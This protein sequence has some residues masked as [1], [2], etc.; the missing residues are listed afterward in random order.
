MKRLIYFLIF[1]ICLHNCGV[2]SVGQNKPCTCCEKTYT[3]VESAQKCI[4]LNPNNR[5]TVDNRLVLLAIVTKEVQKN[6]ELGWRILQDEKIITQAQRKYLLVTMSTAAA[7]TLAG[8]SNTE[9]QEIIT[10]YKGENC[11][12]IVNQ[13]LYPFGSWSAGEDRKRIVGMLGV[14]NGP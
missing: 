3:S 10:G 5:R 11:F 13:A 12:I 8:K 2:I 1:T 7:R 14:G 4:S 9:L 6:Q